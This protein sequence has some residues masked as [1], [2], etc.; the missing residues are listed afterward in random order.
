VS[1]AHSNYDNDVL[2]LPHTNNPS[3]LCLFA[4]HRGYCEPQRRQ[5]AAGEKLSKED[6]WEKVT[7]TF[8][9]SANLFWMCLDHWE[10]ELRVGL[11]A[12]KYNCHHSN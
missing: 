2:L 1:N 9:T 7:N 3:L 11:G 6:L 8:N 4:S 5:A 12:I 10:G